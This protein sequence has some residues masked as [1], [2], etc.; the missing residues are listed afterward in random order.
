MFIITKETKKMALEATKLIFENIETCY[1]EPN[2]E[3]ARKNMLYASHYAGIAFTKSYVGYVHAVAHTLGGKYNVPHGL[4]NAIILPI[5]LEEYGKSVYKK[6][7]CMARYTGKFKDDTDEN[8]TKKF[9]SYIFELNKKMNIPMNVDLINESD[10]DE[11]VE[12]A[13]KEA[14]P[15]YP[16]PE[17]KDKEDL[18]NIYLKIKNY[19][20]E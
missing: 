6:I 11:L 4:A 5:M 19:S 7:A 20:K 1:N 16:V 13:Y 17:L 2:N 14:N 8:L 12:F 3:N 10:I 9:I 15:L 18:K